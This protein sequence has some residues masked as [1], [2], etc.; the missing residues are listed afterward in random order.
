MDNEILATEVRCRTA[1][2]FDVITEMHCDAVESVELFIDA[3]DSTSALPC[4]AIDTV[5]EFN[6]IPCYVLR[7]SLHPFI[8]SIEVLTTDLN[9]FTVSR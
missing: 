2:S 6:A 9:D 4:Q 8:V 1:D 5:T 3:G 7:H